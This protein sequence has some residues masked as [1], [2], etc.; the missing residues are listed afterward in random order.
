MSCKQYIIFLSLFLLHSWTKTT[1]HWPDVVRPR[2]RVVDKHID[3][4]LQ[5]NVIYIHHHKIVQSCTC[6]F[7]SFSRSPPKNS[8]SAF[9]FR[10]LRPDS[11]S[12]Y[13]FTYL[14]LELCLVAP[15]QLYI[16]CCSAASIFRQHCRPTL[17]C[18][19][20]FFAHTETLPCYIYR[21]YAE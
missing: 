11:G 7:L 2:L 6:S 15:I 9:I 3:R 13:F 16:L 17:S 14:R 10:L 19:P 5:N 12:T 21:Y 18:C 1:C 4:A 20:H 8:S